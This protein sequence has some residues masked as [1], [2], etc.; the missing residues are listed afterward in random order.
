MSLQDKGQG[1]L[2]EVGRGTPK[3]S[4]VQR[5]TEG[6]QQ[7]SALHPMAWVAWLRGLHGAFLLPLVTVHSRSHLTLATASENLYSTQEENQRLRISLRGHTAGE[8]LRP[9]EP[10][11]RD[12]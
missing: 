2:L 7:D 9:A 5:P 10:R 3:S 4:S 11:S 1:A 6:R 8:W 12:F